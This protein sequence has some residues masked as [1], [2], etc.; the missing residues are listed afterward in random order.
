MKGADMATQSEV[1]RMSTADIHALHKAHVI[2]T[3]GKRKLA[4]VRG[5]GM[6]LWDAEGREYL[7]FFAGIAV[8]G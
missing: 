1:S 8:V 5:K 3:Y 4:F 7:D 2:D 6:S